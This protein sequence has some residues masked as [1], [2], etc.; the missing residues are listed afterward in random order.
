MTPN[1]QE[2]AAHHSGTPMNSSS[3]PSGPA[4]LELAHCGRCGAWSHPP[5]SWGCRQCG[6]PAEAL[7]RAPAPQDAV[8]LEFVTLHTELVAHLP[9]PCVVAEV[10]LAPGVVEEALIVTDDER[11][12]THGMRLSPEP[13]PPASGARWWFRPMEVQA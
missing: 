5:E 4:R 12:L 2:T 10:R 1:K 11:A 8:L 7:S 3:S 9:V 6:A 13:A